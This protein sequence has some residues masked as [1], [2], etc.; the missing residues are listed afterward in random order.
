[1]FLNTSFG[2]YVIFAFPKL[3]TYELVFSS[4]N[5]ENIREET[6]DKFIFPAGAVKAGD[7]VITIVQV[8]LFFVV[9]ETSDHSR[10]G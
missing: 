6:D 8:Y 2:K 4:T 10:S 1:M 3:H 5:N 9:F 7:N